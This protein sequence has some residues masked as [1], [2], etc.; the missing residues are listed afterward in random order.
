MMIL[1]VLLHFVCAGFDIGLAIKYRDEQVSLL[2]WMV[3]FALIG[4]VVLILMGDIL[5]A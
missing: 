5:I 1:L 3:A 2:F 4:M